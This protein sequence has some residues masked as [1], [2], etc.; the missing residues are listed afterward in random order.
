M[1]F[2]FQRELRAAQRTNYERRGAQILT[3][4]HAQGCGIRG[5]FT[6]LNLVGLACAPH[7][8]CGSADGDRSH[9]LAIR[10][11]H[12]V[13]CVEKRRLSPSRALAGEHPGAV[14]ATEVLGSV[15]T[16]LDAD[17]RATHRSR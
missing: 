11:T 17:V 7:E 16:L 8:C 6:C 9:S 1:P 3:R 2:G 4:M 5:T 12:V 13:G 15:A 10:R 14:P